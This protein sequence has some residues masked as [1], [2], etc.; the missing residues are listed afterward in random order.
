MKRIIFLISALCAGISF[1]MAQNPGDLASTKAVQETQDVKTEI[2]QFPEDAL[3]Q[4]M[5]TSL[6]K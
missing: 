4:S 1:V 3:T 5:T 2:R 6:S